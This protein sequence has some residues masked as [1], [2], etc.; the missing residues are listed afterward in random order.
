MNRSLTPA[1]A[2]LLGVGSLTT[3]AI[4]GAADTTTARL[5][6][7]EV[8]AR[9][10]STELDSALVIDVDDFDTVRHRNLADALELLP[11]VTVTKLG[12]R[13]ESLI[14][15]RG[16]D[17]RQIPLFIDG[18][19]IYVPYDGNI[20]LSRLGVGDVE[21]IRVSRGGGSVLYGAN[22]LGG[23]I[24]VITKR[25]DEGF[26]FLVRGSLTLDDE[27]DRSRYE[28]G[29]LMSMASGPWYGQ[30][31]VFLHD[32]NFFR[33][34]DDAGPFG[35][36][37]DGGR[38]NNSEARDLTSAVKVG[39]RNEAGAE[40][41]L[42][43]SRSDGEKNT[44]P[45]AGTTPGVQ[46][47]YWQWPYY[48][49]E[50]IYL[51]GAVP[52]SDD[53]WLRGRAFYGSFENSL[54]SYDDATYTTQN[55]G[56]AFSSFYDDYTWG[57]SMEAEW[58]P[59]EDSVTRAVVHYKRD[60]HREVD[61]AGEPEE[62]QEDASWSI[63]A[64]HERTLVTDW[65]GVVGIGWNGLKA[66]RADNNLGGGV[67]ESFALEDE[68]AV[69]FRAGLAWAVSS[70]WSIGLNLSRKTRFP[71]LK[72]RYSYRL[73]R[74]IPN[75][76]LSDETAD[77]V[78][79][80]A[81]GTAL[82][83][84]L[85]IG[86]F[87]AWIDDAIEMV[88]V[89]PDVCPSPPCGQNQNIGRQR[90]RGFDVSAAREIP[91]IGEVRLSYAYLDRDNLSSPSVL[92]VYTPRHDGRLT[93]RTP[94]ASW[95]DLTF[96]FRAESG[97]YSQTDGERQ[98]SGFGLLAAGFDF[99]LGRGLRLLVEGANVADRDYAYDEGFPESG[100]TYSATFIWQPE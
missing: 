25:P 49:T 70:D 1:L 84:T 51:L 100:R 57:G 45:Y 18:I 68:S 47:R 94:L 20:D 85:E 15:V 33:M 36:G 22:S 65:T 91:V 27:F 38:R 14:N 92:P 32:T 23:A 58:A 77:H 81:R 73:G 80:T 39:W 76:A 2:A 56:Y 21:S 13:S 62:V 93:T 26:D 11:G 12:A 50:N 96:D 54:Q 35:V 89:S 30:A 79:I 74:A 34:S 67:I 6:V 75:E 99:S 95:V 10:I 41:Q 9:P 63:A 90:N 44:P 17:S 61:D 52:V 8:I 66:R 59:G 5:P 42:N 43:Y 72:D 64:E 82:G 3:G 60:V 29:A 4:A 16:F 88:T 46:T 28:T 98:T 24:N 83:T 78:D 53:L 37:E 55:A 31:S 87:G 97:R 69:N 7:V 40:W 48:D 71:T 86:V 19:P